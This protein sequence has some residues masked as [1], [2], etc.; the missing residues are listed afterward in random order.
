MYD[1]VRLQT[2]I[3]LLSDTNK[4]NPLQRKQPCNY[5]KYNTLVLHQMLI[6]FDTT[7]LRIT[8]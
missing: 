5:C 1:P 7:R 3:F 2:N 4:N 8:I 6:T